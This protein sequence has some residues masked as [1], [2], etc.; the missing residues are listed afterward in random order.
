MTE[1]NPSNSWKEISAVWNGA[2][3]Y[4]AKSTAGATVLMGKDEAGN[5]G[6]SPMELLLIGLAGCTMMDIVD[7]MK[8]KRQIPVN[9]KVTVRGNQRRTEYPYRYTEYQVEYLLWG[10]DLKEKDVAQAIQ[11]SEEKYCSVG[12]TLAK[13]GPI[14]SS[15][16]ILQPGENE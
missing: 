13:S 7:I 1:A 15:F 9:F 3:G 11:L 10:T 2:D 5:P 6:S 16:R 8:K 12:G 14:H 4:L